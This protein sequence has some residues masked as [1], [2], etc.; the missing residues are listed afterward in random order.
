MEAEI[1]WI[2]SVITENQMVCLYIGDDEEIIR[3]H[4]PLSGLP[5]RC[6]SMI[7]AVIGPASDV[8]YRGGTT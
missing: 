7:T 4:A 8:F 5:I 1:Q 2:H 3:P 6:I